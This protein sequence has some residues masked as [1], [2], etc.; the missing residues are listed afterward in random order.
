MALI[1]V[2]RMKL[3][4]TRAPWW[5]VIAAIIGVP[6]LAA[7]VAASTGVEVSLVN[8]VGGYPLG[9][10]IIMAM[11]ALAVTTEFNYG[12]IRTSFLAAPSRSGILFAKA[13]VLGLTS[14]AVGLIV[15]AASWGIANIIRPSAD[16]SLSTVTDWRQIFGLAPIFGLAGVI[17]VAVGI[18]I[19]RTAGAVA[20]V[21]L[22]PSAVE[23]LVGILP[24]I[25]VDIGNWLPFTAARRFLVLG[26]V[27]ED[28]GPGP[29]LSLGYFA[30]VTGVLLVVAVAVARRR[31]A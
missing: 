25:G 11:A 2:E 26:D 27:V 12:T 3:T 28:G 15:A 18:L 17:S 13:L 6:A 20:A 7:A 16:L 8:V 31:D 24:G 22:W 21:V 30:A 4:S 9:L 10:T 29:W 14:A 19:R 5:C 23:P 1:A